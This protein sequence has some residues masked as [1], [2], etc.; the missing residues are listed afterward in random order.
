[1]LKSI[2]IICHLIFKKS[3]VGFGD[4]VYSNILFS[5]PKPSAKLVVNPAIAAPPMFTVVFYFHMKSFTSSLRA[6]YFMDTLIR[7]GPDNCCR[8]RKCSC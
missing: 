1:M 3:E 4:I 5:S 2:A 7:V 6:L 8:N